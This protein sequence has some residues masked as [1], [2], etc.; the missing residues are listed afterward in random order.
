MTVAHEQ[1]RRL[2]VAVGKP[3]IP[4]PA[5][6]RQPIVDHAIVDGSIA[7]LSRVVETRCQGR[8]PVLG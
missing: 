4:E 1:V 3:G 5:D 8:T 2:D 6:D 7:K